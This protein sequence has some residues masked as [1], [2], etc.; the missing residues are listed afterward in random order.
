MSRRPVLISVR[1]PELTPVQADSLCNFLETLASQL[2]DA[3]EE[4]ILQVEDS[5]S[6]TI[7]DDPPPHPDD[8]YEAYLEKRSAFP[9]PVS[10]PKLDLDPES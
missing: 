2:W 7:Q 5:F 4:D 10:D 8:E 9:D 6:T 1:L 3:Y